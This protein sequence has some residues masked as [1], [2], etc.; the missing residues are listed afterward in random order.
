MASYKI[1]VRQDTTANW[2]AQNPV[3]LKGEM[4]VEFQTNAT[5]WKVGDGVTRWLTLPYVTGSTGPKG[6]KGADATAAPSSSGSSLSASG[7]STSGGFTSL[8][9]TAPSNGYYTATCNLAIKIVN[10][11]NG[12]MVN[13]L[14]SAGG[15]C[16][17]F[18]PVG[19]GQSVTIM[20]TSGQTPSLLKFI[21]MATA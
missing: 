9:V 6:D 4:G 16:S 12:M 14:A 7:A 18:L 20:W 15:D 19:A 1:Q 2:T 17:S 11:T 8:T 13:S 5:A 10:N 3:L 21:P